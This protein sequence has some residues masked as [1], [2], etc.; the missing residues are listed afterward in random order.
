MSSR[1]YALILALVAL[2]SAFLASCLDLDYDAPPEV[3]LITPPEGTFTEGD[4]V[5]LEFTEPIK[6]ETFV[7]NILPS[8]RDIEKELLPNLEPQLENCSVASSPCGEGGTTVTISEDGMSAEILT[9][10]DIG[11]VGTPLILEVQA[12]LTDKDGASSDIPYLL[13]FQISPP[14]ENCNSED[15]IPFDTARYILLAET[16]QPLPVVIRIIG[17]IAVQESG[18]M[19]IVG[20]KGNNKDGTP[21]NTSDPSEVFIDTSG[22]GFGMF[23]EGCVIQEEGDERYLRTDPFSVNLVIIGIHV[24]L[25]GLILDGIVKKDENGHDYLEGTLSFEELILNF[26]NGSDPVTYSREEVPPVPFIGV[27]IPT[28]LIP[29]G[30][31]E[32]CADQICGGITAQCDPPEG[33][34]AEGFCE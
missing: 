24:E 6:P 34:P 17:E 18:K 11:P 32:L 20:G 30:T 31:P 33:F 9:G 21:R 1:N 5:T 16:T 10:D 27:P 22:D 2:A 23:A 12:G 14:F 28:D 4:P 26:S 13:D 8:Q 15:P 7:F 19:A 25:N 29:E 3:I